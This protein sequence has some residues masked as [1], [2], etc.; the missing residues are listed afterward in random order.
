MFEKIKSGFKTFANNVKTRE[1]TGKNLDEPLEELKLALVRN[2]VALL[3]AQRIVDTVKEKL[4]G[5]RL[6]RASKIDSFVKDIIKSSIR[7][8]LETSKP[9]N[10]L[11]KAK[12]KASQDKPFILVFLGVNG[13]GKTTTIAKVANYFKKN[14]VTCVIAASDTYRAGAID[15]LEKHA[16]KVG[17]RVIK[18]EYNSDPSSVAW[19]AIAHA[20]AKH[21]KTVLIDTAGRQVVD[22][23]LMKEIAKIV[24]VSEPDYVVYVGD[25]MAGNDVVSQVEKFSQHV[26]IDC[27]ILTKLDADPGGA[28]LSV[29]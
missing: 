16:S 8:I 10:L 1:L 29:A 9:F 28:T 11:D 4:L 19:D 21:I 22:K 12:E 23:N 15:Q 13:T 3:V 27:S 20:Q 18:H 14:N 5:T 26:R 17:I 7:E 6:E 24:N 25:G 2:G